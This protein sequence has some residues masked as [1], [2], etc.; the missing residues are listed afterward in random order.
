[1][2]KLV[3]LALKRARTKI[4]RAHCNAGQIKKQHA[5]KKHGKV[6]VQSP[7]AGKSLKAGAKVNLTVGT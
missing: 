4:V 6:L 7:R 2:P 3:G 1:M 5:K